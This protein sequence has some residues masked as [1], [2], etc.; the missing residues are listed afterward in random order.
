ML[1]YS[2]ITVPRSPPPAASGTAALMQG[3]GGYYN[4]LWCATARERLTASTGGGTATVDDDSTRTA[5]TVYAKGLRERLSIQSN[6]AVPWTWRRI[7]FTLKGTG[8]Y[9]PT[10]PLYQLTSSG[11]VRLMVELTSGPTAQ[12]QGLVFDGTLNSDW[13]DPLDAKTDSTIINIL[14]DSTVVITPQTT[15]GVVKNYS[16]YYPLEKNLVYFEDENGGENTSSA[17]STIGKPGMGD[18]LIYDIFAPKGGSAFTDQMT[19]D[20]QSTYYWHEK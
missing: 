5:S 9:F 19:V 11:Y 17:F 16:R 13:R 15:S 2:N 10:S 8:S 12:L 18:V 6:S 7:V 14:S 20:I 3:G 1:T 4:I